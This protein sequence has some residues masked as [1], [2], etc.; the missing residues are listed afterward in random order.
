MTPTL[1]PPERAKLRFGQHG[2]GIAEF[3]R[4]PHFI[5]CLVGGRGSGKTRGLAED[6]TRHIWRN[7]GAKAIV[8]RETE[9]SQEDSSID[10][11]FQFFEGLGGGYTP[12]L[13]LFKA[14]NNG[15]TFRLPSRLAVERMQRDCA[16]MTSR[17]EIAHWIMTVGDSL[18]GYIEFRGLPDAD[19]GKFRGMECS[20]LAL[21]EADQISKKQFDLSLAC[22]RWKGTDP[23]RCDEKGFIRDRCVV[24]DTNPPSESH[25]IAQLEAEETKKD[26]KSVV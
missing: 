25:W 13:G 7:A 9:T 15:R 10:T 14:W 24:L 5:R 12:A 2:P 21:V 8:A 26:R 6:I 4:D 1:P 17:A 18:C 22:L 16:H 23:S 19:K 20:Y 3:L 11:F